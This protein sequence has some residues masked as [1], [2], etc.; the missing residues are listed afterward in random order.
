MQCV[1]CQIRDGRIP[2]TH[3]TED[4]G[5][6]AFMD[7]NP[8]NDGHVLVIP[9]IHGETIFDMTAADLAAVMRTAKRVADAMRA[10]LH[11]DGMNLFQANGA[12][13]SQ[14][15]PHFHLHLIP[16]WTGDGKGLGWTLVK[17]DPD[18]IRAT[19]DRIRAHLPPERA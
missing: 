17:G 5:T 13:A 15:I 19:A 12:A 2:S 11:P 6:L 3:V 10:A 9:K 14:V 16:R 4:A 8:V 7:I 1:F 18:R